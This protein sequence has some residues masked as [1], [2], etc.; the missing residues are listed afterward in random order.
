MQTIVIANPKGGSGKT[1]LAINLAGYFAR[2]GLRTGLYDLDRQRST[3]RWLARR[4]HELPTIVGIDAH[5]SDT[6]EAADGIELA[7]V[8][9]PAGL[10]GDRLK[11]VVR[12]ADRVLVPVHPS[13]LDM[14]AADDFL[15]LLADMKRVRKGRC[16]PA[17]L[18]SRVNAR[19]LSTQQLDA[20]FRQFELPVLAMIRETQLYVQMALSGTTLFDL[21][22]HRAA[23][24]LA[25][26]QPLLDWLERPP[27]LID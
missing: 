27:A 23:R 25:D 2:R 15:G 6:L 5:A 7:V 11:E 17:L 26:W 18:G 21:P 13:P 10:R 22:P 9:A 4:P 24:D 20:F 16:M 14:E 3:L 8:D 12:Q 1:T 19:A